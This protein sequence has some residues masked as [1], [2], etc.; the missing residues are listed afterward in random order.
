MLNKP[1]LQKQINVLSQLYILLRSSDVS[2]DW[3]TWPDFDSTMQSDSSAKRQA[4][5]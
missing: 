3:I 5:E 4:L 1:C 2:R